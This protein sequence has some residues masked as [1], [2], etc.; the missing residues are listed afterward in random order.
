MTQE[1][2]FEITVLVGTAAMALFLIV[3]QGVT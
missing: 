2:R 3:A 1:L